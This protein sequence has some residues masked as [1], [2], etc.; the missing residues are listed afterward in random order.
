MFNCRSILKATVILLPLLGFTWL[1]GLLAVDENS[2]VFA[3]LFTLFNIF[4]VVLL[5]LTITIIFTKNYVRMFINNLCSCYNLYKA[6]ALLIH[7][8]YASVVILILL[9]S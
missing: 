2:L 6:Q 5:Y 3:W 7:C 8:A 1:F 9:H 4:Q